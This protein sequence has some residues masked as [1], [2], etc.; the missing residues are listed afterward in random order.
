VL[1]N[2]L[3]SPLAVA[4]SGF[5]GTITAYRPGMFSEMA[6]GPRQSTLSLA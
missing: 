2:G 1:D 5:T 3:A 4:S 6:N